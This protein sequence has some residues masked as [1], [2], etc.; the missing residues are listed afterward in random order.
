MTIIRKIRLNY[1]NNMNTSA[2]IDNFN[3]YICDHDIR[4]LKASM[5]NLNHNF[6]RYIE[7]DVIKYYFVQDHES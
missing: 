5:Q 2:D 4:Y 7:Y 6:F 3:Q 1:N